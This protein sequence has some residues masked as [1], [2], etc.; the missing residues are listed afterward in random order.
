MRE[1]AEKHE[2]LTTDQA[3]EH[4][5]MSAW[6]LRDWRKRRFGP[7]CIRLDRRVIYRLA[8]IEGWVAKQQRK[9]R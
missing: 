6:T 1:A 3:A 4:L 2:Y 7:P 8:D 5:T 9:T